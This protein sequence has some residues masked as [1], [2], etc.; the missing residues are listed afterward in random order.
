[1]RSETV[2]TLAAFRESL[3]L[4]RC[5]VPADAF[6]E[7]QRTGKAKQVYCSEVKGGELFAFAGLWD[8]NAERPDA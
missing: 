8:R 1:M 7:W 6:Y 5:L 3:R 4:R 2:S